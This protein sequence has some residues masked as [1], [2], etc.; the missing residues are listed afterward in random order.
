MYYSILNTFLL[1]FVTMGPIKVLIVF[2]EM[3]SEIDSG[4]RRKI[5]LKAVGIATVVGGIFIV[6]GQFLM[7][8]FKFSLESLSIAG[9]I[10][11]FIFAI[12]MVLDSL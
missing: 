10:I 1:L 5:A 2:A 7:E 3:T 4:T 8:L 11:L 9:G 6:F 12:N